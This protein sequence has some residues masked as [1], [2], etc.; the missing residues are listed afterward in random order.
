[1]PNIASK[2]WIYVQ[3]D[4]MVGTGNTSTNAPS[5]AA[6]VLAKGIP[7]KNGHARKALAVTVDC[8]GRYV[9]QNRIK[10]L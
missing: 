10:A 8:N 6:I 9:N 1:L 2:R 5:D 7:H 3:Y 4:S